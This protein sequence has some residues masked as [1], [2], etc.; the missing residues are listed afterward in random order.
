MLKRR[1]FLK[2]A[3]VS[4]AIAASSPAWLTLFSA[5]AEAAP[6]TNLTDDEG[7]CVEAIAH[8]LMPTENPVIREAVTKAAQGQDAA[9]GSSPET[10]KMYKDGIKDLNARAKKAAGKNFADLSLDQRTGVLKSIEGN[11]LF[12]S[13]YGT[14]WGVFTDGAVWK[15]IGFPGPSI[16]EGGYINRGF[17]KLEW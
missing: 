14:I 7:A 13:V 1:E 9:A 10:L 8:T 5:R 16:E 11:P 2:L 15:E 6:Y 3:A 12:A 4:M 17:D